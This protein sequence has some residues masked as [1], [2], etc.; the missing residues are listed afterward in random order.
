MNIEK[1]TWNV[2]ESYFRDNKE[3]MVQH[4]IDSFNDFIQVKIPNLFNKERLI[5][6]NKM[7]CT[8]KQQFNTY[9]V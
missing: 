2:I 6:N 1:E 7:L 9:Q 8:L 3:F 5:Q 4:H